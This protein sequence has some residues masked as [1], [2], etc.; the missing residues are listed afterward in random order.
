[1]KTSIGL[2]SAMTLNDLLKARYSYRAV[3]FNPHARTRTLLL[4]SQSASH[5]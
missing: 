2:A 4:P 3:P 1:M 5:A